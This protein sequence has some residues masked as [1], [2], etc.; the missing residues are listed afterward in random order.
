MSHPFLQKSFYIRW[1][2]LTTESI[3]T[4]IRTALKTA[5][6]KID[7]V[8]GTDRGN[9]TFRSTC[10]ALEEATEELSRAWGLVGHLDSVCNSDELRDAHNEILPEVSEFYA[11][12]P[13]DEGLWDLLKTFADTDAA[14]SLTGIEKRYFDET[15]ADFKESGADL[16]ETP[17]KRLEEIEAELA[18]AT[19]KFS[20]NVLDSTNAWELVIDDGSKLAGLPESAIDAALDNAK[21]KDLASDAKPA[22]RFTLQAPSFMPVMEHLQ[23]TAVRKTVWRGNSTVGRTGDHDNTDLVWKIL[24]LRHEKAELLGKSHFADVVLERRMAKAGSEALRFTDDL[25]NRIKAAFDRETIELQ[26][27]RAD[28]LG[29]KATLLEP[30]DAAF[31]AEKRRKQL[32]DFDDEDLR[33]YF[34]I[35]NVLDGMFRLAETIFELEIKPR[36]TVFYEPG[37]TTPA[38]AVP[39]ENGGPVEVWHAEVKF[40]EIFNN[41]GTHLG[42]F[43]A[44]WHPREAKR[45]GAWMNYL[46]TGHPPTDNE[47]RKPHLGL[48][49]GNL[50][51]PAGDKPALLTHYEVETVFHEF[52]H[53]LHHLLGEVKI[54]SLNGVNVAWD[55]VELPS[56]I[57]ENFCWERESL[58][59]FARHYQSGKPIPGKLYRRMLAARNYMSAST[60]MRQL[61]FGKLDLELHMNHAGD[62]GRDLDELTFEI[63]DRYLAPLATRP[64]SIARRFSHLF[65]SPTGYAAGYYS[66]KWAEVLDADAFTRFQKEGVLNPAVGRDFKEKILSKGN[67][68]PAD[69]LFHDFMGRAPDLTALLVRSGLGGR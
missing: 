41:R 18:K 53:L 62:S 39:A 25:H 38:D 48:I 23:D 43:Y 37:T 22:W 28:S 46:I 40:F 68:E 1:S 60:T 63:L 6:E 21:G 54:R 64:P 17:K 8:A 42:S 24:A 20:E 55:F 56:Q 49:C 35:D 30:W 12:I 33:P 52:G 9:M 34:A 36:D 31:W 44:D 57:M 16:A 51:P 65:G 7:A 67:S 59:F 3:T 19:Q 11:R 2:Q 47:D 69:K 58:D 5:G 26:E 15:L 13:L 66:Y 45:G 32:F 10:L 61:A 50:T 14:K 4:D 27:Y 29:E